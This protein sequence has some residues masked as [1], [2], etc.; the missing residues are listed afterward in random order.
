[1]STDGTG[2]SVLVRVLGEVA[3][4]VN[5]SA[6]ALPVSLRAIALLAWLAIHPGPRSRSEI[7]SALWPDVPDESARRS[8]RTALWALR[9][10]LSGHADAVLDTSRNRIGLR[11]DIVDL[12]RFDELVN[13]G[14]VDAALTLG[15]GDLLAGL[16]DE[17]VLLAR[18]E[19][20]NRLIN[21]LVDCSETAAKEGNSALAITRAR[22]AAELNPLSESCARLLMR[23]YDEVSDR[24]VALAVYAR[25]VDRLR[26]E[27]KIAPSEE[28]WRLAEKIRTRQQSQPATVVASRVDT[29]PRAPR[30]VGRA[31][32]VAILDAAWR[33][34]SSGAGG[35]AIIHG[36]PGAGKTRLAAEL[37]D[38]AKQAGALT[39]IG[40]TSTSSGPPYSPWAELAGTVLRSLG[41]AAQD[42]PFTAALAPLLPTLVR[43]SAP[44][45]PDYEQA[46]VTE[47]LLD[48]VEFAASR[49]PL[50]L[51]LEDMHACDERS[52]VVLARAARRVRG[53]P[54]LLV[55]TRRN[56]SLPPALADA[57]HAAQHTGAPLTRIGLESLGNKAVSE[58][59]LGIG[60]LDDDALH[61]I[62][63]SAGGNALLAVEA[64]RTI[65][66]GEVNL[67]EGLR[68]TVRAASA[69]L[70][71]HSRD[72]CSAVA[73]AGRAMSVDDI[74]RRT[75]SY[76]DAEFDAA[77]QGAHDAHLLELADGKLDFRHALLREAYYADLPLSLRTRLHA[78]AAR[79]LDENGAPDLAAEAARHLLAAGDRVGATER[80]VRAADHALS[81]GAL[82]RADELLTD[83]ANLRPDGV[84]IRLKQAEV[85]THLG[86]TAQAQEWFDTA[87]RGLDELDDPVGVATAHI[88]WAEWNLAPLCRP[89][90][91]RRSVAA[92]SEILDTAGLS[93][94]RLRLDAQAFMAMCEAMAGS[95]T[96]ADE[97]LNTIDGKCG[98]LPP[99]AIRDI[100]RHVARTFAHM[101]QGRFDKIVEA[102]RAAA[103]IAGSIGRQD[104][105]YGSLV[106]AASGL[107]ITGAFADALELLDEIGS[108][109]STG[110]LPLAVKAEMQMSRA[111]LLSR[112]DRHEEAARVA[113]TAQRFAD[114]IGAVELVARADAETGRVLLRAGLYEEGANLLAS[115]LVVGDAS[116][117][118]PMARLQRAEALVRLGRI[119]DAKL[120]LAGTARE[121]VGRGDWPDTLV[122]RMS[123]V[124][125]LIAAAEG[126]PITAA[127]YFDRAV[128]T[129][130]RRIDAAEAT[131]RYTAVLA[132]IGRPVVGLIFP[133]DELAAVLADL[134]RIESSRG[135]DANLR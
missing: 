132:D 60:E 15:S 17:W 1:M 64:A 66:R 122:A 43:S 39:A 37:R 13:A 93:A 48:L 34:A 12:D 97:L 24:S 105:V 22:Q 96:V 95:P 128:T 112:L 117:G 116:I 123:S 2:E 101:R 23:R 121:P 38:I 86:L 29:A 70:P 54:V 108:A 35:V 71:A 91:A 27:L 133:A 52:A 119:D 58:I 51:I 44:W 84:E 135:T 72:L 5:D 3:I 40:T 42:Q 98:Q 53:L 131:E 16:D 33:S 67:A 49:T 90:V 103:N 78:A 10:A 118:R 109:P 19:H 80:L 89:Q 134:A 30:L 62:V 11:N 32:E 57:E 99:D 50:L 127:R 81:L 18:D 75:E 111:W 41:S 47:G 65:V 63:A 104:L 26:N 107:A 21:L 76:G 7:A 82:S 55:W 59:A 124:R 106:N 94:T 100:R 102:A 88:R 36:E 28:T 87:L 8:V 74:R 6:I 61:T 83:A 46:R 85:A 4:V 110:T 130:R 115:A 92:A 25:I 20:R 113:R 129:W 77:F 69:H 45:P 79:D 56:R 14:K 9:Q 68:S 114:R 31:S 125:G 126:D 120:E 73:V